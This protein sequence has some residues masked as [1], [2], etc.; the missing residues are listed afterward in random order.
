[1]RNITTWYR[2]AKLVVQSIL[3]VDLAWI[4][5]NIIKQTNRRL[6][7]IAREYGANFLDVHGL[8]VDAQGNVRKSY[9]QD[10]GVHLSSKGY[11]VWANEVEKFLKKQ[12]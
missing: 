11:G 1:M 8:F 3:P 7:E 4:D 9:L 2:K 6:E 12:C 5:N 10:D